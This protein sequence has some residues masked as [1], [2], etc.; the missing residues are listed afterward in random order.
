MYCR[1]VQQCQPGASHNS[2]MF[3]APVTAPVTIL[4]RRY[5]EC[6]NEALDH[7]L[8]T[9]SLTAH[10]CLQPYCILM[11]AM[12]PACTCP[13]RTGLQRSGFVNEQEQAKH[14]AVP[15][16]CLACFWTLSGAAVIW[17]SGMH[18][19]QVVSMHDIEHIT[20]P[21]LDKIQHDLLT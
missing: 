8:R 17:S 11:L 21:S 5:R 18:S 15:F 3:A 9:S 1:L 14:A 6:V 4:V 13:P 16:L 10:L 2:V 20:F 7:S 19:Q 12:A